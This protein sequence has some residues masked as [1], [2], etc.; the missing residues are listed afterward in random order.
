MLI[1][2]LFHTHT[3]E[4]RNLYNTLLGVLDALSVFGQE[5]PDID[6]VIHAGAAPCMRRKWRH[7][8]PPQVLLSV[9]G[10]TRHF[11]VPLPHYSLWVDE[12]RT[13]LA[14]SGEP[15]VSWEDVAPLLRGKYANTSLLA[16]V[17]RAQWRGEANDPAHPE[18]GQLRRAF[19]D[20]PRRLREESRE[21]EAALVD[22]DPARPVAL[23]DVCD[24]RYAVSIEALGIAPDLR[25]KLA[26]GSL[27]VAFQPEYWEFWTRALRAG[28]HFAQLT[29]EE[30]HVCNQT[31]AAV[32]QMN[33]LFGTVGASA[34]KGP[35]EPTPTLAAAW[36]EIR[37]DP[38]LE[39]LL[40]NPS[41]DDVPAP[42]PGGAYAWGGKA[43]PWEMAWAGY[44]FV[45]DNVRLEDAVLYTRDLF[46]AYARLQK[47]DVRPTHG[48]AC[49][50]GPRLL[51]LLGGPR[52]ALGRAVRAAH[53]W[54]EGYEGH[55][56][57]SEKYWNEIKK[58]I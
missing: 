44:D 51:A 36:E 47:H 18:R 43:T 31:V 50:N 21:R 16:R 37:A 35:R 22:V 9:S 3:E 56:R 25:H 20:C 39:A 49:L 45:H 52:S 29:N 48:A 41:D 27:V 58:K 26:C 8:G 19:A 15:L 30:D 17:P 14:P 28:T 24:S 7:G 6:A 4:V 1:L 10:S 57:Q 11:D 2:S 23:E 42:G 13:V 33:A 38:G 34:L 32:A 46:Q 55:C 5:I 40:T 53:P 12:Q 54:L